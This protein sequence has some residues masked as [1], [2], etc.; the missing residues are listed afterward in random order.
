MEFNA[1][2]IR[3]SNQ[4]PKKMPTMLVKKKKNIYD[5]EKCEKYRCYVFFLKKGIRRWLGVILY[6][7]FIFLFFDSEEG[8]SWKPTLRVGPPSTSGHVPSLSTPP[9]VGP[10]PPWPFRSNGPNCPL[11][12]AGPTFTTV[13]IMLFFSAV[14]WKKL[15]T[16]VEFTRPI[17]FIFESTL[18]DFARVN[19][20]LNVKNITV[21][22]MYNFFYIIW[23]KN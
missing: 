4:P 15:T 18:K 22:F 12:K 9:S 14:N 11:Y 8:S 23:D 7:F 1:Y 2:H 21:L 19:F 3:L 17:Y 6:F 13:K 20:E 10:T 16:P 5:I